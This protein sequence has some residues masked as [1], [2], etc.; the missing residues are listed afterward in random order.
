MSSENAIILDDNDDTA[1]AAPPS[2]CVDET[3][4]A[5]KETFLEIM[6]HLT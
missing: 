3:K 6:P 1:V 5:M 4:T 2:D